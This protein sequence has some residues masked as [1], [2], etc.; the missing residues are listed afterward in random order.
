MARY[1]LRF[2]LQEFELP[3]GET[4]IGR[5]A[6]CRI[7]IVDPLIS[8]RH[9]RVRIEQGH[10]VFE[11]LASRNGSRLNGALLRGEKELVDGDRIRLGGQE[12]V[13][14]VLDG[15]LQVGKQTGFL[16]QCAS[17]GLPYPEEAG[18]CPHCG[19]GDAVEENTLTGRFDDRGQQVWALDLLIEMIDKAL[20]IGRP[21]DAIRVLQQATAH[22]DER[23]RLTP[24]AFDAKQMDALAATIA[25]ITVLEK[26]VEW[27]AWLFD[28]YA[29]SRSL[30]PPI[31]IE[32]VSALTSV[33]RAS[34]APPLQ[35]LLVRDPSEN[36]GAGERERFAKLQELSALLRGS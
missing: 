13:F 6:E 18:T 20:A 9:A 35:T 26:R 34:L 30:P 33:D 32:A 29:R 36:L 24:S 8:R 27:A 4:L 12:L 23:L 14:S 21:Q 5:G 3:P 17:C 31:M 19:S 10:A 7:T 11:D 22:V 16:R 1:R 2:L 15:A 25:K 28:V